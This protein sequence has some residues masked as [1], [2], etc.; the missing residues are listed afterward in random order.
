MQESIKQ[1]IQGSNN[2][3]LSD[4]Y[5]KWGLDDKERIQKTKG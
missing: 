4:F 1:S 3:Y 5:K 2:I